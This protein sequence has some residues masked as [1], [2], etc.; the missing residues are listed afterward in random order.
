MAK[1]EVPNIIP[2]EKRGEAAKL[3]KIT[4]D[5]NVTLFR[6]QASEGLLERIPVFFE[7]LDEMKETASAKYAA[8]FIDTAAKIFPRSQETE[9]KFDYTP[10]VINMGVKP[11]V[12]EENENKLLK[13][14]AQENGKI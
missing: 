2:I 1:F 4:F 9:V 14:K 10:P 6:S 13:N 5:D 11:P 3:A 7:A 8:V 12:Y